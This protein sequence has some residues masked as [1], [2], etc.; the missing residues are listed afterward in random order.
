V[1]GRPGD[2]GVINAD[3]IR[4]FDNNNAQSNNGSQN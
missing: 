2:N 4:V 1:M 3:L